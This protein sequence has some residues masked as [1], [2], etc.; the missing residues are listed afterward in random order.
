MSRFLTGKELED[1]IT[2][3]IWDASET[4][5]IVSPFIKL[6][7]YFKELFKK[8][9]NNPKLHIIIVF[10][11]NEEN[12]GKSMSKSDFDFFKEF[13]FISVVYVPN[14]H[15]KYY[16]N[17][18]Q[19]VITSI[20]MYDYSF[21]NNI[22]F[23]VHSEVRILNIGNRLEQEAWSKCMEI[24]KSHEA[25]FIKRPVY[26]K[27]WLKG[28]FGKNYIKSDVILDNTSSF[29]GLF[30]NKKEKGNFRT[31]SEFPDE[32]SL[33]SSVSE[34][35]QRPVEEK[36]QKPVESNPVKKQNTNP[37]KAETVNKNPNSGHFGFCIRTGIPIPFNI[38]K[39]LCDE[40]FRT[41]SYFGNPDF[42]ESYCHF[43]GELSEGSTTFNKPILHKNWKKANEHIK[44][45]KG[46]F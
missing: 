32:L 1:C 11:K 22:E 38:E 17:E 13:M 15:A 27:S 26:Q 8:H 14:L 10:G 37:K 40:A 30:F 24:A 35:P 31:I 42:P 23:G 28:L 29:Y 21:K 20:N 5:L 36:P 33:E 44:K 18:L 19:G 16:G 25:V 4:L 46:G 2:N 6:D 3:I 39:P 43:S 41:W 34:K 7:D 9:I 12:V 45:G